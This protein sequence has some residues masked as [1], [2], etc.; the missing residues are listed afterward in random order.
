MDGHIYCLSIDG[1]L[2]WKFRTGGSIVLGMPVAD[3]NNIYFASGDNNIYAIT[4]SGTFLWGVRTGESCFNYPLI[5][6]NVLYCGSRDRYIYA[7]NT[8]T[9]Q[10]IWRFFCNEAIMHKPIIDED[11]LYFGSNKMFCFD[12]NKRKE[13][14][15]YDLSGN[16]LNIIVS[17]NLANNKFIFSAHD[18]LIRCLDKNNGSLIWQARANNTVKMAVSNVMGLLN[19]SPTL[20]ETADKEETER[21][22]KQQEASKT[23]NPYTFTVNPYDLSKGD[24]IVTSKPSNNAYSLAEKGAIGAYKDASEKKRY[25]GITTY[26]E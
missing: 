24:D 12:I 25:G 13:V 26:G 4:Q 23:F 16:E 19:W 6:N 14:W 10:L 9:G 5:F 11:K 22:K 2:L 21:V 3:E 8:K 1:N 7:I 17:I 18:N 15:T 20:L